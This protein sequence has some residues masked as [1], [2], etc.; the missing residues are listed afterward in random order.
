MV[1][2][3]DDD[4]DDGEFAGLYSAWNRR[5]RGP[6]KDPN[7]FPK[8][9]SEEGTKLMQSGVFGSS[10]ESTHNSS[11]KRLAR[12]MLDR[13]LGLGDRRQRTRNSDLIAQVS[14]CS[15]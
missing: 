6:P 2:G 14:S 7:R 13:E 1:L 8:V 5:R 9:P 10:N 15:Q 11:R 3:D 12:R 4:D